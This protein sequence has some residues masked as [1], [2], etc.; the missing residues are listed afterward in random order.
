LRLVC[1]KPKKP[2]VTAE[3]ETLSRMRAHGQVAIISKDH[4]ISRKSIGYSFLD[5]DN[6][7]A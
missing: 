3:A 2:D 1:S 4:F 6:L 7:D 5:V